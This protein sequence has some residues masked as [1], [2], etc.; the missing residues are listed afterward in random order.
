M[1]KITIAI[2]MTCHNRREI[3][4]QCL[5]AISHQL[6]DKSVSIDVYLVDDGSTDGTSEAIS[7]QFPNVNVIKGD[8][9]LYWNR[10]MH[11]AFA[12]ALEHGYDKYL[13]LN[14]DTVLF[15]QAISALLKD[16]ENIV[17]LST[18][19]NS[20]V[21]LSGAAQ[22]PV[23]GE[24]TYGGIRKTAEFREK[25]LPVPPQGQPIEVDA[26]N[27]NCVLIPHCVVK[28]VGNLDPVFLHRWGDHDYCFRAK[29]K[30]TTI[31][32]TGEYV[33]VCGKNPINGSWQDL[34]LT[35]FQRIQKLHEPQGLQPGNYIIYLRR[36][37]GWKWPIYFLS[38][39][40][41]I[42]YT[43]FFGRKISD[44]KVKL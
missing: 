8:G 44:K 6:I 43:A 19:G 15:P 4:I 7:S 31:W 23:S 37:R 39:Y 3:T 41:T 32:I 38:P 30:G 10:G 20:D 13:W 1:K 5:M 22:D 42:I 14:D 26:V 12:C 25:Y 28:K 35:I 17:S 34:N 27:G 16:W 2:L 33:A 36:W 18:E 24:F 29:N 21:I 11:K 9:N 40:I